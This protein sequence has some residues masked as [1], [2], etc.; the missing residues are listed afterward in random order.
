MSNCCRI[1][2]EKV[3][4]GLTEK[5][6][7]NV[8]FILVSDDIKWAERNL[9]NVT[10]DTIVSGYNVRKPLHLGHNQVRNAKFTYFM[11][12]LTCVCLQLTELKTVDLALLWSCDYSVFDYGT[13]GFWGAFLAGPEGRVGGSTVTAV[14]ASQGKQ[15]DEEINLQKAK[16][17]NFSFIE[18]AYTYRVGQKDLHF[19]IA[20]MSVQESADFFPALYRA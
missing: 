10:D 13:F 3:K 7:E 16:L 15:T 1:A 11:Q 17:P 12:R 19:F 8:I 9:L 18:Y 6:R 2:F 4:S 20:R 5:E 14:N